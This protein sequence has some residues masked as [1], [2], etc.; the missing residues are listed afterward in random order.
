M[1]EPQPAGEK[2]R[3]TF[4][5]VG[6]ILWCIVFI[7]IG[8]MATG[9]LPSGRPADEATAD[10]E[11]SDTQSEADAGTDSETVV[12]TPEEDTG[13]SESIWDPEGIDD[14]ELTERSG[15]T[16][17]KQDLL[18]RPWVV[19]FIFIRCAGPCPRVTGQMAVLQKRLKEQ[20]VRMVTITVDPDN[21]TPEAL[22]QYADT[23]GADADN[24]W[25]LTGDKT[26]IYRLIQNSFRM[27]VK[28][29]E[30]KDRKPGFEVLHTTNI[31]SVN[32]KGVVIG[33]YNAMSDME[34]AKLRRDLKLE[35]ESLETQ[36][37][38][39]Q[40][41]AAEEQSAEEK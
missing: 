7:V 35:E 15:R 9:K 5:I 40:E 11:D 34:L 32:S 20:N 6:G 16:I 4:W 25:F 24:W 22:T 1:N 31:L 28:E 17:S 12:L 14:F 18:G 27:P 38:T 37:E 8:L 23:W 19:G 3:M 39:D 33:K 41:T 26:K 10:A 2:P 36:L 13:E 29:L 21:D 30:G